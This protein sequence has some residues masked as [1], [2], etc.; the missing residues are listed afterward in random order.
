M[1]NS[2]LLK[3]V[4]TKLFFVV[5]SMSF[6]VAC[7][8]NIVFSNVKT[9]NS[10]D[11]QHFLGQGDSFI[12]YDDINNLLH[13][14]VDSIQ[15]YFDEYVRA[16]SIYFNFVQNDKCFRFSEIGYS[17]T[18]DE[19]VYLL[20]EPLWIT[21]NP[22][23]NRNL[24]YI[25]PYGDD[26]RFIRVYF[27]GDRGTFENPTVSQIDFF[28]STSLLNDEILFDSEVEFF[29]LFSFIDEKGEMNILDIEKLLDKEIITFITDSQSRIV[30]IL[31]DYRHTKN[32][33]LINF[34]GIDGTSSYFDVLNSIDINPHHHLSDIEY[35]WMYGAA[36]HLTFLLH[37]RSEGGWSHV[38]FYFNANLEVVAFELQIPII[39]LSNYNQ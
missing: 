31:V 37:E 21:E 4:N 17:S 27:G 8:N 33:T 16:I 34:N 19:V 13:D 7:S 10:I 9:D 12:T 22:W 32:I 28:L 36:K 38:Q 2:F 18:R 14:Y 35:Q 5:F 30:G 1:S 15:I 29:D 20:G 25:F 23:F 24:Q 11:I 6:L 26:M 39:G 3:K